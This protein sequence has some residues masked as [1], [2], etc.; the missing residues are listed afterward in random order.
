MYAP[1][2]AN[3]GKQSRQFIHGA[4]FSKRAKLIEP[5]NRPG[6]YVYI[7]AYTA[8]KVAVHR[9]SGTCL[10]MHKPGMALQNLLIMQS[11]L[12]K[13]IKYIMR[14]LAGA[15]I[16]A[17][18]Q[19]QAQP[20]TLGAQWDALHY[21]AQI[22]LDVTQHSVSGTVTISVMPLQAGLKTLRLNA[23]M[24]DIQ[25]VTQSG[26]SLLFEKDAGV[27]TIHLQA[28]TK[29]NEAQTVNVTY[30]G[31]PKTG[32]T[33]LP[34][35]A[36]VFTAFS[37]SQWMPCID[38]PADRATFTLTLTVPRSYRVV[39]NGRLLREDD[40]GADKKTS[41]WLQEAPVPSYTY[42]FAAGEFREVLD[43]SAQPTLR[44]L[45]PP[46]FTDQ[47]TRQIFEETRSMVAFY[48]QK[49]GL[50][51]PGSVYTQ[52]LVDGRAAQ[53]MS[54]FAV[55]SAAYG[56]RVLADKEQ[57]WLAAHELAHQWWGNAV[58]NR[59]WNEFW[60]N[61]GI[62]SYL[63][64]AYFEHRFG[65]AQ[66]KKHMDGARMKVRVLVDQGLDKPLVFPDWNNPSAAD[67]SIAYDKGAYVTQLLR[68]Q[69][70]DEAFWRGLQAYTQKH[71]GKSV[72]SK[73]FQNAMQEASGKDLSEFFAKWVDPKSR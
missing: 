21:A 31:T 24:L 11:N 58:T 64:A 41:E 69:L 34:E 71:W 52:V 15:L 63:N 51:Y 43:Q 29:P 3:A 19:V 32:I 8:R 60:L 70:G 33:F 25:A 46:S 5:R 44:Y 48:Q 40:V 45:V 68:A 42:G 61:E 54:G 9:V 20:L 6:K 27:L 62:V 37:T 14:A 30:R 23:G 35:A 1:E 2:Q 59:D 10:N 22:E 55:M 67:R 39:G 4:A 47:Q 66:Y 65:S 72:T 50:P 18:L 53:E 49:A 56:K 57:V 17:T 73:D 36:Q 7:N 28:P 26:Q 13:P 16:Y 38:A 12:T